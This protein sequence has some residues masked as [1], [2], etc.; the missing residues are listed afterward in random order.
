MCICTYLLTLI[1]R[2]LPRSHTR[3]FEEVG[4][5]RVDY[6]DVVFFIAYV[7]I[8][9]QPHSHSSIESPSSLY[10]CRK[11][12]PQSNSPLSIAHTPPPAPAVCYPMSARA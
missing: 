2:N 6:C 10:A 11:P 5:G 7:Y 4:P 3:I 8:W 12:H 9:F 1:K